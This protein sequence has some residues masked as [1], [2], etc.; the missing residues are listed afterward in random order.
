M[1][2]PGGYLSLSS[3]SRAVVCS[4]IHVAPLVRIARTTARLQGERSTN[5]AKP[6]RRDGVRIGTGEPIRRRQAHSTRPRRPRTARS[7]EGAAGHAAPALGDGG[8]A[9]AIAVRGGGG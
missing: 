7:A 8:A 3:L 4:R 5:G 6:A 9:Q 2:W 1:D